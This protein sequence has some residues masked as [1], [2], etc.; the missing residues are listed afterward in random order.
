MG[1]SARYH[2]ASLAA[3]FLALAIGILIGA[4]LG[5]DLLRSGTRN[6]EASL[7]EDVSD[8]RGQIADLQRETS[9]DNEFAQTV[10][11]NLVGGQLF[12]AH[13][14]VVAFGGLDEGAR[15]DVRAALEPTGA[16]ITQVAIIR[17]PPDV[18]GLIDAAGK[19]FDIRPKDDALDKLSKAIGESI[20]AGSELYDDVREPL[21]SGFSGGTPPLDGVLVVRDRPGDIDGKSGDETDRLEDGIIDGMTGGDVPVVGVQ[22]TD[23][24]DSSVG[25]FESHGLSTVDDADLVAGKVAL[26]YALAGAQGNFGTGG[27]ADSLLPE[28]LGDGG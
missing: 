11:P 24:E 8:A 18:D 25:Y 23:V 27:N 15:N 10:Y 9:R 28:P 4:G 1:Y 16:R 14:G 21:L 12:G 3:V 7:K 26:V 22:R 5:R 2:V 20:I 6:L 17:E 19:R 13:I